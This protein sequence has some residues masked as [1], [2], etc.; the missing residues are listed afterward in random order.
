RWALF[1]MREDFIAG[2]DPYLRRVPTR[3]ATTFRLD[4]LREGEARTAIIRPAQTMGVRFSESA[5]QKLVDDLRR[6]RIQRPHGSTE[7]LG[8]YIEPVQLQVVCRALWERLPAMGSVIEDSDVHAV[9]DVD[10]AL[11]AYGVPANRRMV[12]L[13]KD[14]TGDNIRGALAWMAGRASADSTA[15]FFY[16]GHVRQV[17]G[18]AD[19][20]G[21]VIDEA[22][23]G[24]DG[25]NVF[26]GQVADLL[27][28]SE[29]R[30][31][32]LGIAACYGAGFDDAMAP[33]RVLTA[34]AGENDVAY[35]NSSL[36]HSYMVEYMVRRA[37]LQGR[38]P[39][40]VQEAFGWARAQI[41]RDYPNRQPAML[42]RSRGPMVLG[43]TTAAPPAAPDRKPAPQ[44]A[45]AK[46]EDPKPNP[47]PPPTAPEPKPDG[48]ACAQVLGVSVC[49]DQNSSGPLLKVGPAR[50][51]E[52]RFD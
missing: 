5:A 45:P 50:P 13:D 21:E 44:P 8:P 30:A 9:G 27:R 20:D 41:A 39:G 24:A 51:A 33:G 3:L 25:D 22:L 34:A 40:S 49:S 16:S 43:R 31:T 14:A 15:V 6:V 42:D 1:V 12:L 26:D 18:D 46:P 7:E 38:A 36:G 4:L 48:S 28:H 52:P 10:S 23:V 2:L 29:A 37:M 47:A 35:E 17:A 19:R 11:A 32:W